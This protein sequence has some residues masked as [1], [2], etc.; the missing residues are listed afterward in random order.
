M[1]KKY[2]V[3]GKG[4]N[5]DAQEDKYYSKLHASILRLGEGVWLSQMETLKQMIGVDWQHK[6]TYT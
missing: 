5:K 4:K 6:S 3:P 2:F 1:V